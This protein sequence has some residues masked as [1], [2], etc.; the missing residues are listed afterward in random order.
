MSEH[1]T[2]L[3]VAEDSARL[4]TKDADF[5]RRILSCVQKFP[6]ALQ[7]GSVTRS[8][9]TFILPLLTKWREDSKEADKRSEKMAYIIGWAGHLAADRTF[10]PVL[11]MTDLAYYTR[12]FP[13]PPNASVYHDAVVFGSVY[14]HGHAGPFHPSALRQSLNGHPAAVWVPV[15]RLEES[16]ASNFADQLAQ[17]RKYL[18]ESL[19]DWNESWKAI[20]EERQKFYVAL[21]RYSEAHHRSDPHRMSQ[22]IVAPNFFN[23]NDLIIQL[24]RSV[25][26]EE[27]TNIALSDALTGVEAQSLYAQAIKLGYDFMKAAS[28]YFEQRISLEEAKK[29]FRIGQPH[30]QSLEYY[31]EQANKTDK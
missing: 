7:L 30:N 5:S 23:P 21:D 3:A 2:H 19:N 1:I 6:E 26:L 16:W 28:D 12:G 22:Y 4:A 13:G 11:R 20:E 17:L 29:Q 25:Q 15:E 31:I 27:P 8:G 9:D 14:Q 10:N 18:P 24:A